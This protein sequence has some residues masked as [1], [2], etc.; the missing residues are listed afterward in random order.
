MSTEYLVI[1]YGSSP[2]AQA[3]RSARVVRGISAFGATIP[4]QTRPHYRAIRKNDER[5]PT[6]YKSSAEICRALSKYT[7]HPPAIGRCRRA[8]IQ[9][10]SRYKYL[11]TGRHFPHL[12]WDIKN[13]YRTC[14]V[15]D[16]CESARAH[17]PPDSAEAARREPASLPKRDTPQK[18]ARSDRGTGLVAF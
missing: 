5:P 8:P 2:R 11:Q 16:R 3:A 4:R 1:K 18:N 9:C 10:R 17:R 14:H 6:D 12:I 15:S 13:S 7:R